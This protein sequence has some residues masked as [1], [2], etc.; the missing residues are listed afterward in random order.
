MAAEMSVNRRMLC[1]ADVQWTDKSGNKKTLQDVSGQHMENHG[2]SVEGA[3]SCRR[4]RVFG[5]RH[6]RD[7]NLGTFVPRARCVQLRAIGHA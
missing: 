7:R 3:F 5:E 6:W 2:I 4:S 1:S